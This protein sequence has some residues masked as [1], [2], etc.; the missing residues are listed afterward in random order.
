MRGL[1]WLLLQLLWFAFFLTCCPNQALRLFLYNINPCT[2]C[3]C[4]SFPVE[5]FLG[6]EEPFII[7][8]LLSTPADSRR[9]PKVYPGNGAL[10]VLLLKV[11]MCCDKCE[12][13][14]REEFKE[15]PRVQT[16]VCDSQNEPT[17]TNAPVGRSVHWMPC[18]FSF[19]AEWGSS[20]FISFCC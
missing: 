9:N 18:V 5:M 2:V 11:P 8:A 4:F 19:D 3:V 17:A 1:K 14:V 15:L 6:K 16:I 7:S 10:P 20:Q 12:E 13:K